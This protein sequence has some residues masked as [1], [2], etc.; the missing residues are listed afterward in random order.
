M[1]IRSCCSVGMYVAS[2]PNRN[3]P[4]AMLLRQSFREHGKVRN[5]TLANLS[6]WPPEQVEALRRVLKGDY[7]GMPRLGSAFDIM[8][9]RP[10]GHV[11]AVF[12]TLRWLPLETVLDP[13]PSGHR[14]CAVALIAARI[15]ESGSKLATSRVLRHETCH[16]SLGETLESG[17]VNED[18]LYAGMDWLIVRQPQIEVQLARRHLSCG[19]LVLCDLTST[20]FEGHH[21]PLASYGYSRDERHSNLQIVFGVLCSAQ[22]CPVAVEVFEG[23]TGDPKTV[24]AQV[25]KVRHRFHLE[26]IVLVGDRET[27][28]WTVA[29]YFPSAHHYQ[30]SVSFEDWEGR[31]VALPPETGGVSATVQPSGFLRFGERFRLEL[32]R[33][34]VA[35]VVAEGALV[36][37]A[38]EKL[39]KLD[40]VSGLLAV[41]LLG[42]GADWLK[43][44]LTQRQD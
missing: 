21:C 22:G 29:H 44:L 17:S 25:V 27:S 42:F 33:L 36:A 23:N 15:L 10:H 38:E 40:L 30:V 14:D 6:H 13:Q 8:C 9:S 28:G 18:D 37:G 3:S 31:P 34:A 20:Y 19:T 26:R 11:A 4:P 43:N 1:S 2:V 24:A 35:I 7:T 12:G 16:S 32:I 41:F 5:R 39:L